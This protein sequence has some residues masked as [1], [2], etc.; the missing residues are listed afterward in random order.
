MA[1]R[2]AGSIHTPTQALLVVWPAKGTGAEQK[3][4]THTAS[5]WPGQDVREAQ[6]SGPAHRICCTS[7]QGTCVGISGGGPPPVCMRTNSSSA[8]QTRLE[9]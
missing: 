4:R 7:P 2:V 8:V 9:G 5:A 1:S 3:L 6:G